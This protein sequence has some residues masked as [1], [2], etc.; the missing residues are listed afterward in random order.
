M[1]SFHILN[2]L[3]HSFFL[4]LKVLTC[5]DMTEPQI[6]VV[7]RESLLALDHLH[8]QRII[9]RDIKRFLSLFFLSHI[10]PFTYSFF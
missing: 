2:T 4:S 9:H 7:T 10:F 6:A 8:Q 3:S 1:I 5:N